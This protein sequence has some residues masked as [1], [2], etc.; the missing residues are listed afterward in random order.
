MKMT[1]AW[2]EII[3]GNTSP[4]CMLN[5]KKENDKDLLSCLL[6]DDGGSFYL[7][8]VD[9]YK[10]VLLNIERILSGRLESYDWDCETWAAYITQKGTKIY[11]VH[12]ED[13]FEEIATQK[14]KNALVS[15][16]DF[17]SS[18]PCVGKKIQIEI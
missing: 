16:V 5:D 12:E 8:L 9:W 13:Y 1:F 6:M 10:E 11:S 2:K 7:G 18:D 3:P 4:V 14:L 15:W 17:I